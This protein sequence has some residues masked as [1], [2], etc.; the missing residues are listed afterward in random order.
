MLITNTYALILFRRMENFTEENGEIRLFPD[1]K[2]PRTFE[3]PRYVMILL[4]CCCV[5]H[6]LLVL[7]ITLPFGNLYNGPRRVIVNMFLVKLLAVIILQ[8][9]NLV[10]LAGHLS[11]LACRWSGRLELIFIIIAAI[12]QLYLYLWRAKSVSTFMPKWFKKYLQMQSVGVLILIPLT[13][14][15]LALFEGVLLFQENYWTISYH[16]ALSVVGMFLFIAMAMNMLFLF[17][18]PLVY[19]TRAII[20]Q[21][22][23]SDQSDSDGFES[24]RKKAVAMIVRVGLFNFKLSLISISYILVNAVLLAAMYTQDVENINVQ[25][26]RYTFQFVVSVDHLISVRVIHSM[27]RK[28]F[29]KGRVRPSDTG[30]V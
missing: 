21:G 20:S 30:G 7:R 2:S 16:L 25:Y 17:L 3:I 13:M 14:P 19:T 29:R 23:F 10:L 18:Y 28:V 11:W 1:V 9:W 22:S 6:A 24:S 5:I 15:S 4:S 8:S 12:A 26:K 27:Y